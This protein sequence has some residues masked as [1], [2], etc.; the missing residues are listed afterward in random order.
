MLEEVLKKAVEL[1]ASDILIIAGVP[2]SYKVKGIISRENTDILKPKDT[3]EMITKIYN[4]ASERDMSILFNKGDDDFSFSVPHLARFRVNALKQ[5]GSFGVVIRVV[6]FELP[7]Y[8]DLSILDC[9]M[10]FSE[11]TKGDRKSVV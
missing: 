4:M 1:K 7:D 9:I 11:Y 5:R 3:L 8:S 2:V 6:S 10:D